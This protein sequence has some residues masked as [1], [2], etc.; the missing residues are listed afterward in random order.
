M[1]KKVLPISKIAMFKHGVALFQ[2]EGTVTDNQVIHLTFNSSQMNDVLKSLTTLDYDGGKFAALS[3]DSEDPVEKRLSHLN[4]S[5]PNQG[6]FTQFLG[7]LKGVTINIRVNSEIIEGAVIGIEDMQLDAEKD[8][9]HPVLSLWSKQQVLRHIKL[10]AIEEIKFKDEH[11]HQEINAL[12]DIL[13]TNLRKDQKQLSINAIGEGERRVSVTYVV[14]SP[15]W[16]T[17]YRLMLDSDKAVIQGWALIDNT[18]EDD[19]SGVNLSLV[20]GLPISFIHDL[21]TPRYRR[22]SVVAVEEGPIVEAPMVEEAYETLDEVTDFLDAPPLGAAPAS[23]PMPQERSLKRKASRAKKMID[24]D[25]AL[26]VDTQESG[27]L[28]SYDIAQAIDVKRGESALVPILQSPIDAKKIIYYNTDVHAKHPMNSV[29]LKNDS[30]LTLEGGPITV[31]DED[32]YAGEAMLQTLKNS[33][34]KIVPYSIELGAIVWTKVQ[35][36]TRFLKKVSHSGLMIHQQY[37]QEHVIEYHIR[38]GLAKEAQLYFD[39]RPRFADTIEDKPAEL[40]ETTDRYWRFRLTVP[41]GETTSYSVVETCMSEDSIRIPQITHHHIQTLAGLQLISDAAKKALSEIA[42]LAEALQKLKVKA[43]GKR[44]ELENIEN[45]Q[46]RVRKNLESLGSTSEENK[47][48]QRYIERLQE[49][50]DRI[51]LLL[52]EEKSLQEEI[53]TMEQ[54]INTQVE[55]LNIE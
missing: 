4:I 46:D 48:R 16:K 54:S 24:Q 42:N 3:Y 18:T 38:S 29:L 14:E 6:S 37:C 26:N 33:A 17:S 1:D 36:R 40:V 27:D 8:V 51:E 41:A 15:V 7:Q 25:L 30:G 13:S 31:F 20:S 50:E 19:W 45:N 10:S 35:T 52:R 55:S 5:V 53:K 12:L 32:N 28:F 22:R 39:H 21:Y 49:D 11:V 2:R 23:A 47:L 44:N 43:S 9:K 34:D